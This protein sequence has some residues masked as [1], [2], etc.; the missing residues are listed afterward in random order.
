MNK[1]EEYVQETKKE[2][3]DQ[4]N[5]KVKDIKESVAHNN[6]LRTMPEE[7][8]YNVFYPYFTGELS[9]TEDTKDIIAKWVF[10]AGNARRGVNLVDANGTI[11]GTTPGIIQQTPSDFVTG[12]DINFS[13]LGS[14]YELLSKRSIDQANVKVAEVAVK[15]TEKAKSELH[16]NMNAFKEILKDGDKYKSE[17]DDGYLIYD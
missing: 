7:I 3:N 10:Y 14:E 4:T 8:Y 16:P 17:D 9:L 1:L 15:I 12:L 11:T 13:K 6:A 2:I 5:A